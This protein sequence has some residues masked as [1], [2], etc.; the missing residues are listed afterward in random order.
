MK[1]KLENHII[2]IFGASGDLSKRKLIPAI[3]SLFKQG[4]LSEK[5]LVLGV[6]RTKYTDETYQNNMQEVLLNEF[7]DQTESINDFCKLLRY[8]SI[9]TSKASEYK[10]VKDRLHTLCDE[11]KIAHNFLFYLSTPPNL[12]FV[13]P[14]YLAENGLNKEINGFKRIIIEKPFGHDLDSAKRLNKHLLEHYNESQLYRIDHYL[15]KET[16]QNLMVFR[17][18][19]SIFEP[20]WNANHIE[21]IQISAAE[22]I[23][24]EG[25]GG[26]YEK[27]GVIRDMI[28]NHLLQLLGIVAMEPP[29]TMDA[30]SVRNET[31]KVLQSIRQISSFEEIK[32]NIV[33]G[34]YSKG[35]VDNEKVV[36]YR[37]EDN[38]SP[39]SNTQ[40]F[41]ALRLYVDNWRWN[42]IPFYLRTGKRLANRV[43]EVV[44]NFKQTPHPFFSKVQESDAYKNQLII[45]IQPDEGI[46][47][48]FA[49]KEPGSGF[50]TREIDMNF[51]YSDFEGK[52]I[53]PA[54]ERLILDA[55]M[56]DSTL[57]SR[58]DAV[59]ACWEIVDPIIKSIDEKPLDFIKFYKSGS[60]GPDESDELLEQ[61]G[62]KWRN[63]CN[64][65]KTKKC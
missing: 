3:Y 52:K 36:S 65:L 8:Q 4:L 63:P 50:N 56:G 45:R 37:S 48:T 17:F 43:S 7:S 42:G 22:K 25:R 10:I 9:D 62:H 53:P 13:I 61:L 14:K 21:N 59:E 55:L 16:V 34:Q 31:L 19:N 64:F 40:T 57:F 15:G 1:N 20:L 41:A 47:L 30:Y 2:I 33:V 28:Q 26:Y 6:S 51:F 27:S 24:I 11:A 5:H 46:K 18:A 44:I 35:E 29:A 32:K 12:Y 23:G 60:W 49:A 54:Y 38:V 39:E 58:D